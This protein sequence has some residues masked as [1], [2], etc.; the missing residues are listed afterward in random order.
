MRAFA[1]DRFSG[2]AIALFALLVIWESRALPVGGFANPGPGAWPVGLAAILGALGALTAWRGA[3]PTL[4]AIAWPERARASGILA[5]VAF[6][7]GAIEWLGYRVTILLVVVFLLRVLE[8][9]GWLA[10]TIAAVGLS[11]G[12][13]W[14][15]ATLLRTPLPLGPFGL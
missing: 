13:Y 2:A 8:R 3:G 5:I 15:F 9:K 14:L 6:A 11:F 10:T 12:S 7:A 1:A 4:V